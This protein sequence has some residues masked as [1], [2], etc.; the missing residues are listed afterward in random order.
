MASTNVRQTVV[1]SIVSGDSLITTV[2]DQRISLTN[3]DAPKL[4][5]SPT[6]LDE[7]FAF[8]CREFLRKKLVGQNIF[9]SVDFQ[10]PESHRLMCSV[11]L[12][13]DF[14]T[15]ENLTESLLREGLVKLR[16]QKG[17]R[18]KDRKY[19]KLVEISKKAQENQV[20]IYSNE[21]PEKHIRDIK[22]T[23]TNPK[24]FFHRQKSFEPMDAIVE[25]IRDGNTFRCL[26]LPSYNFVTIQLTGIRCPM[27]KRE[28][29]NVSIDNDE[30]FAQEAKDFVES[31][32]L[33]RDVKIVL[34][35]VKNQNLIGTILHPNGN[36]SF[37]LLKEGLAK[38][39]DQSMTLLPQNS[40]EQYRS[41][42]KFAKDH[43]LRI[44]QNYE[45]RTTNEIDRE[46]YQAKVLEIVYADALIVRD[47]RNDQIQRIYLSSIRTPRA[48]DFAST[49]NRSTSAK[50]YAVKRP[51]YD[52]PFLWE[53]HEF[54]RNK[55]IGQI[56]RIRTDYILK[57]TD[58]HPEKICCSIYLDNVNMAEALISKGLAKA[59]RH[60]QNDE[61]RSSHYGTRIT[62]RHSISFLFIQIRFSLLN[63]TR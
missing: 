23:L 50:I 40:R 21:S 35:D 20:G 28:G 57:A 52:I 60:R 25:S 16:Q 58:E 9:Y 33:Q 45:P 62:F 53:G 32:L 26:L 6:E 7:P 44:W 15:S 54:L 46:N 11:Y 41:A 17:V 51:L 38:C 43:R 4:A 1:K 22:W 24:D 31:R 42:E 47:L 37:F 39:V 12:G 2:D 55:L 10:I 5:R 29:N 61:Q 27:L 18:A 56:V 63:K 48:A 3:I 59:Q 49:Q 19:R 8:E 14:E 13:D 36:I 34:S 30:S